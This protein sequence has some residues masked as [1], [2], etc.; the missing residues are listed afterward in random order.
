MVLS[1]N[2][3]ERLRGI[4]SYS[5]KIFSQKVGSGLIKIN[6]EASMQLK[7]AYILQQFIPLIIFNER[8]KIEIELESTCFVNGKTKEIDILIKGTD[9]DLSTYTIA[10][11]LKCYKEFASSGRPRG[12]HD[13]FM[14]DVY[15]DLFLLEQ[16]CSQNI[17]DIGISLVMS[18]YRTSVYPL[19]KN[20]KCW[21]YDISDGTRINSGANFSTPVGGYGI[22]FTLNKDYF[23]NWDSYGD[24]WF[25]ELIGT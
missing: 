19:N 3:F 10:I 16:Y 20:A 11:E 5:W 12:A 2:F 7:Y 14:K 18:N 15:Y 6:K 8:Q 21:A 9:L 24:Y 17:A 25:T 4:V 1:E 22:D 23:F 13:I